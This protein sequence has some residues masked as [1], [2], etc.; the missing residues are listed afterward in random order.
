MSVDF[1]P[2]ERYQFDAQQLMVEHPPNWHHPNKQIVFDIACPPGSAHG[3]EIEYTRWPAM[4]IPQTADPAAASS[5][6][7][8]RP[9]FYDY[10]PVLDPPDAMGWHVNFADP[11]LFV[12]YGTSLFAQDEMQ[13]VEHPALGALK[14]ALIARG[15]AG[16]TMDNGDPTPVLVQGVE[17]RCMVATEPNSAAGRPSGLYGNQF[18][19]ADAGAVRHAT[20]RVVPPTITNL[21][22]MA[23]P[24]G[25]YGR[26]STGEIEQ[27]L[28]TAF[29][30]YR[31]AVI[32][33]ARYRSAPCPVVIHT[34]FWGCGAFG[35]NRVVMTLLQALAAEMAGIDRLVFHTGDASGTTAFQAAQQVIAG[36]LNGPPGEIA[37]MIDRIAAM[38]FEWGMSDGN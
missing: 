38:G 17:R 8:E 34:G 1:Q 31:A 28:T 7:E 21:I 5:I 25:G 15:A 9:G 4:A 33:A 11:H 2:N 30:G 37:P 3:G 10:A 29:T 35:G 19:R 27:V 36:D 13:V 23:A 6:L 14:E 18:G 22:A 26:Y 32:E 16:V 24:S 20:T 12:A